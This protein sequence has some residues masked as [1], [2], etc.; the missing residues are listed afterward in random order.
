MAAAK[1]AGD[2][3]LIPPLLAQLL[4]RRCT[5]TSATSA[6]TRS[7]ANAWQETLQG[8]DQSPTMWLIS[9]VSAMAR[10]RWKEVWEREGGFRWKPLSGSDTVIMMV[11]CMSMTNQ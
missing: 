6:R 11:K 9:L 3:Q 1:H 5:A 2:V 8:S 4:L 7:T 10:W